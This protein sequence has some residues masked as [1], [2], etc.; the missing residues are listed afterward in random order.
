MELLSPVNSNTLDAAL[1]SGADAVYFG[2]R[3]L[4]ARR[5]A[6]NF[7][8]EELAEVVRKIHEKGAKAHLAINTDLSARETGLA[9]RMLQFAQ[10]C[11]VDAVIVRDPAIL[12]LREF[13]PGL[14]FHL[15]TQSGVSTSEG[16]RMARELGCDRVVLA[17]ELT[18]EE[19]RACC[20][21]E[22]I[23]IEYLSRARCVSALRGG[24]FCQA[25]LAAAAETE[26]P[27]PPHAES[28][29]SW[30]SQTHGRGIHSQ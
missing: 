28:A 20:Q 17:R 9:A 24:A 11:S 22:G 6:S 18:R 8:Q 19:I 5:G 27:A 2:M 26:A 21:V 4:N 7:S 13:F 12:A 3:R 1:Q 10:E 25:G 15:S 23:A 14:E 16:V 30:T 29:G